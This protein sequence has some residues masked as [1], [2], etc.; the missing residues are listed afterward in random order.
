[1]T[2]LPNSRPRA[3]ARP[4]SAMAVSAAMACVAT[5]ASCSAVGPDFVRPDVDAAADWTQRHGGSPELSAPPRS[6]ATLPADRWGVFGDALL[7]HLQVIA[8][9]ASQDIR[10]AA[11]RVLQ[12]RV[13]E[14]TVSAQ[15]GLQLQ[16]QGGITRQRQSESGSSARLVNLIGG[17]DKQLLLDA[18]SAPFTLYQA[19]FD[20][21]WEP[22][23][24]G[25][26]LRS[27]EAAKANTDEQR[28]ALQQA[29]LSVQA[30]LARSYFSMRAAQRQQQ[31]LRDE[32]AAAR[33][34]TQLLDAQYR[35][36]LA[37]ESTV[38]RQRSQVASLASMLPAAQSQEALAM[39]QITLLC[40]MAPGA[41]NAELAS[42]GVRPE[43]SPLPDLRLGLTSDLARRRPDIEAAEARLH[44]ATAG[45]GVAVADLY[46]RI[47][48]GASFGLESTAAS[49]FGDWGSRQWSAGPSLSIPVFDQGR[50]RSTIVL[51]QLQQQEAAVAYQ[52]VVLKA[53]HEVDDSISSYVAETKRANQISERLRLTESNADLAQARFANGL[54]TFLPVL[55]TSAE[56]LDARRDLS[57]SRSREQTALVAIY[58][59]LGYGE[60]SGGRP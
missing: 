29:Q 54:T 2:P 9:T 30:E 3:R 40:G 16:G 25:R 19:G 27:E 56:L 60:A 28:A 20:A 26:V 59:S 57:D 17:T 7:L 11:L 45:I 5:L 48:L 58:K 41:L 8:A 1:M 42:D 38:S 55:S 36:G 24:W 21:S 4:S 53:W 32:L 6:T 47:T 18:L 49:K 50:R 15:R 31:L 13:D 33:E 52:Q 37:D 46:P 43:S 14:A 22:D 12:S 34:M 51:R 10:T 23:L 39:N 35:G 44:A